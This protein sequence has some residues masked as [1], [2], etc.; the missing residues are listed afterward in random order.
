M[1]WPEGRC[2]KR[3]PMAPALVFGA[4][5]K[6]HWRPR[7]LL[8]S[9]ASLA[10]PPT[11]PPG[12]IYMHGQWAMATFRFIFDIQIKCGGSKVKFSMIFQSIIKHF[13]SLSVFFSFPSL[14]ILNIQMDNFYRQGGTKFELDTATKLATNVPTCGFS[15]ST[16][17]S[18][19]TY[20]LL[21][22]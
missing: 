6:W 14:L 7:Q 12:P 5:C 3:A 13:Y 20:L 17:F 22:Q 10:R 16:N 8:F 19:H 18:A 2:E 11:G 4:R 21:V 9:E 15:N 1:L